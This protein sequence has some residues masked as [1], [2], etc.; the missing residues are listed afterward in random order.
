[1]ARAVWRG[2]RPRSRSPSRFVSSSPCGF[3]R[4]NGTRRQSTGRCEMSPSRPFRRRG[5]RAYA[6]P[7][8]R[9]QDR[10]ASRDTVRPRSA[11]RSPASRKLRVNRWYNQTAWLMISGG[12]RWRRYSDSIRQLSPTPA[13]LTKPARVLPAAPQTGSGCGSSARVIE[14]NQESCDGL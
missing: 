4:A 13:N 2:C 9:R 1:M 12:K 11:R 3:R 7:N 14:R 6:G 8:F 5:V 10:M